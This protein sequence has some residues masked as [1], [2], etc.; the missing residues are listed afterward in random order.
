[1][2]LAA[3]IKKDSKI[4]HKA[5]KSPQIY[6]REFKQVINDLVNSDNI[7]VRLEA[8]S[9]QYCP[10]K[11]L[12]GRL[13]TEENIDVLRAILLNKKTPFAAVTGFATERPEVADQFAA[14]D[15]VIAK[16]RQ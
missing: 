8:C 13:M 2:I 1:M 3:I 15:E 9:H 16:I 11:M 10:T 4:F 5:S 7:D 12:T 14:D 6:M